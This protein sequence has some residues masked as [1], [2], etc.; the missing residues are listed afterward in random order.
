MA[1]LAASEGRLD[2]MCMAD[3]APPLPER[4]TLV[5]LMVAD[6]IAR[7]PDVIASLHETMVCACARV[8]ACVHACV[9]A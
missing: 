2:G 3:A 5:E 4:V 6:V 1:L 9:R 8:R 7:C